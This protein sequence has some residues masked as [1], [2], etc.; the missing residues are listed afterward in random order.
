[1]LRPEPGQLGAWAVVAGILDGERRVPG[2]EQLA[3]DEAEPVREAVADDH[4]IGVG[5]D[6]A[7]P[8][9]VVGDGDAQLAQATRVGVAEV[10]VG[11][12]LQ[13]GA[14]RPQPRRPRERAESSGMLGRKSM[15]AGSAVGRPAPGA[16][17][18]DRGRVDDGAGAL[19]GERDSPRRAV[20][21]RRRR[22][23]RG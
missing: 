13:G 14:R 22:R 23:R 7:D 16:V 18:A 9:E 19:A 3:G 8:P 20:G 15:T 6:P 12:R 11:Q 10:A 4:L 5:D 1:M 21:R 17:G 2:V